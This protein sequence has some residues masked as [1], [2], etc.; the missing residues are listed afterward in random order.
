MMG[1]E[2]LGN[3]LESLEEIGIG[4]WEGYLLTDL[5]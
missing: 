1:G 2:E 4:M 3:P 5:I